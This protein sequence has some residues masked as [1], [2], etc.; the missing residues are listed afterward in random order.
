MKLFSIVFFFLFQI[1]VFGQD[2]PILTPNLG[3][4]VNKSP[5]GEKKF[6]EDMLKCPDLWEKVD[7]GEMDTSKLNADERIVFRNICMEETED[8]WEILGGGCSWYCGG[9]LDSTFASSELVGGKYSANNIHDLNYKTAWVEGVAGQGIGEKITYDFPPENPRIT[10]IIIV[11]GYVKS[12]KAWTEN[13]RVKKLKM[14][15]NGKPF[16]LLELA[17]SKQEQS[18]SFTPLG[19]ADRKDYD[20]LRILPRWTITFEIMEV[21]PGSKYEDTAITE[22]YF[23]GIDVH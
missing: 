20:K 15:V 17:N 18:F 2:L 12:P 14:Y 21:Y 8:Y 4:L 22:I 1:V 9:G 11:N 5:E 16:A 10:K 3:Y 19:V 6:H 7:G 23:D 13:S